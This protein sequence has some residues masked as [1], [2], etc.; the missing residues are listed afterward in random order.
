MVILVPAR[1][2]GQEKFEYGQTNLKPVATIEQLVRAQ[3]LIFFFLI[4]YYTV[5]SWSLIEES[6]FLLLSEMEI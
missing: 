2:F 4:S 1:Q 6:E 3:L 5:L